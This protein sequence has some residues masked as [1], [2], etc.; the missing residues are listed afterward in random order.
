MHQ[1]NALVNLSHLSV[2]C[3]LGNKCDLTSERQVS[4]EEAQEYASS[5]GAEHFETSALTNE[6]E[7]I[8]ILDSHPGLTYSN[9]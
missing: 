4:R 6:G 1:L 8:G 5:I 3:V 2:L 9:H 7:N